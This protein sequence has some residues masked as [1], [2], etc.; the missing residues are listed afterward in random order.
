[1]INPLPWTLDEE[2]PATI[3]DADG[4]IV[5]KDYKF[6]HVD[7][8]QAICKLITS[9]ISKKGDNRTEAMISKLRAALVGLIGASTKVE[10]EAMEFSMRSVPAPDADKAVSINAI[11]ALLETLE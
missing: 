7:D 6:L 9:S 2:D 4:E 11:H 1:M 10:L 5:A 3:Y 8:F